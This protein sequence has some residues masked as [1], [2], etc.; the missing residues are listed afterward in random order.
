V[1]AE[2]E[3]SPELPGPPE[4]AGNLRFP[5]LSGRSREV[6]ETLAPQ[7][8][9][10]DH[11]YGGA[12]RALADRSNPVRA[13]SAAYC[14]RELIEELERAALAPKAGPGL[15]KLL[16]DFQPKLE[17]A[18]RRPED[19]GLVY[20]CD[21]AVFAAD[22]FL[23]DAAA[24]HSTRRDRAQTTFAELDPVQ[25]KGPPDTY[26]ARVKALLDF[27]D[28]FNDV[29]HSEEPTDPEWFESRVEGF[30]TFLL[31]WFRPRTFDDFSEIDELLE[32][33]PPA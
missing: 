25:R 27:R 33:G 17:A 3:H 16:D 8:G 28:E 31:A 11:F 5:E 22:K 13:E 15:G 29:L 26:E 23:E 32:E 4:A 1:S 6:L 7:K 14:L 30:E 9:R 12:L 21:P 18:E 10:A 24:G 2:Q 20:N 19:N